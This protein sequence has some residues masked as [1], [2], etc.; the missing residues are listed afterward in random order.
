MAS[1][2]REKRKQMELWKVD[3]IDF[4][5]IRNCEERHSHTDINAASSK[6]LFLLAAL[7][8]SSWAFQ[9]VVS[10]FA[11]FHNRDNFSYLR[12]LEQPSAWCPEDSLVLCQSIK[13]LNY[14]RVYSTWQADQSF[15]FSVMKF[16]ILESIA[17]RLWIQ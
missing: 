7:W 14:F 3:G 2:Q 4:L 12:N 9:S 11:V 15:Q 1:I 10:C 8:K 13:R 5:S 16:Y 17:W 6:F